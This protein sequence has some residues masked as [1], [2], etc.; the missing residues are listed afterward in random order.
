MWAGLAF[1]LLILFGMPIGF[2]IGL[3]GVVG[4]IDMGAHSSCPSD[5]ARSSTV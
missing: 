1:V 3:A 4:L 5:R 2:A